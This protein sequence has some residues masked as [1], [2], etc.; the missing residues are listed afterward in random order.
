MA[1]KKG[2]KWLIIG[3][4]G[5]VVLGIGLGVGLGIGLK[6]KVNEYW[7]DRYIPFSAPKGVL[8]DNANW[9]DYEHF[10][11]EGEEYPVVTPTTYDSYSV[12]EYALEAAYGRDKYN[13]RIHEDLHS[14]NKILIL[15]KENR[16]LGYHTALAKGKV[17]I[18]RD[19]N[20]TEEVYNRI[21]E[22]Y[23]SLGG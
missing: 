5:L 15:S 3:T 22:L 4:T 10:L 16:R 14:A 17:I 18:V 23:Y 7:D 19:G 6:P 1:I 12:I 11:S 21:K 20:T 8:I 2:I 9:R 13:A